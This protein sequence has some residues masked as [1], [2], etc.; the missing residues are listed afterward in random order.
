MNLPETLSPREASTLDRE[1]DALMT[2][3]TSP[4]IR[5]TN[6]Y[7]IGDTVALLTLMTWIEQQ[8][9]PKVWYLENPDT[10]G[11][12]NTIQT[13]WRFCDRIGELEIDSAAYDSVP[14]LQDGKPSLWWWN[15]YFNHIDFRLEF[16]PLVNRAPLVT[17]P[18]IF[19]PLLTVPYRR[20]R[21]MSPRFALTLAEYLSKLYPGKLL[22]VA[23]ELA[24]HDLERFRKLEAVTVIAAP[25]A[26]VIAAIGGC[27]LFLGGDTG[28]SHIAGCFPNVKQVA[29]YSRENRMLHDRWGVTVNKGHTELMERLTGYRAGYDAAPSKHADSLEI[30][31][32]TNHG[33]D[34]TTLPATLERVEKWI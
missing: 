19:A 12:F 15:A 5:L 7:R 29:L 33:D 24:P 34:E 3:L 22:V 2:A 18:I 4:E 26:E 1:Y 28:L 21:E 30:I 20:E 23:D 17:A 16:T 8:Y 6:S 13:L 32:F 25:L 10:Y 11:C 14:I 9:G 31:Y 27:R